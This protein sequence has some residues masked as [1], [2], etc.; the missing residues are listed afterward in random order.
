RRQK[1]RFGRQTEAA[2]ILTQMARFEAAI[3]FSLL[4][5]VALWQGLSWRERWDAARQAEISP[6]EID[7][8]RPFRL[9][10]NPLLARRAEH[11]GTGAPVVKFPST[12]EKPP[13]PNATNALGD[14]PTT[15]PPKDW[16]LPG[17][18]TQVLEKPGDENGGQS[19]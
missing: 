8:T 4:L 3:L 5:H 1:G 19:S 14:K 9:T 18:S 10:S 2:V 17:P 7:L 12:S 11:P 6:L 16:V 13:V 15:A